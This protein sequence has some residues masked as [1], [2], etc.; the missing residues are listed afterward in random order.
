[1]AKKGKNSKREKGRATEM[2]DILLRQQQT[3]L[4]ILLPSTQTLTMH[5]QQTVHFLRC[6][7]TIA[8]PIRARCSCINML[9]SA[10]AAVE[11]SSIDA[12]A[13]LLSASYD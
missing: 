3:C 13:G 8:T 5:W 6:W 2:A 4:L 10:F 12:A 9:I 11:S 7:L 1:M